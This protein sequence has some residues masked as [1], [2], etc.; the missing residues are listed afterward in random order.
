MILIGSM[1]PCFIF[2]YL[3]NW[4]H[5]VKVVMAKCSANPYVWPYLARVC[6][7]MTLRLRFMDASLNRASRLNHVGFTKGL[8]RQ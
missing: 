3:W 2:S 1:E 7:V 6:V 5:E 4:L 8:P